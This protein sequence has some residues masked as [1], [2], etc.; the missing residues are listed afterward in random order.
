MI[1]DIN[2][3]YEEKKIK[4]VI[5]KFTDYVMVVGKIGGRKKKE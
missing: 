5:V 3:Y 4:L 1:F 2:K